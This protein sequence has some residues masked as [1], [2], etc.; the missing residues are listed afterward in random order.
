MARSLA[1]YA[2]QYEWHVF[3]YGVILTTFFV[4]FILSIFTYT[5]VSILY[6][7]LLC[8]FFLAN[9]VFAGYSIFVNNDKAKFV[10]AYSLLPQVILAIA[11][12]VLL[13]IHI[14][15]V[16][17]DPEKLDQVQTSLQCCGLNPNRPSVTTTGTTL[18]AYTGNPNV[19]N[20]AKKSKNLMPKSCCPKL[21]DNDECTADLAWKDFCDDSYDNKVHRYKARA[22]VLMVVTALL[23]C[24]V[25]FSFYKRFLV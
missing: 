6:S 13:A 17:I 14:K 21:D 1:E 10:Y 9:I 15:P 5:P 3:A 4:K 22:I 16:Q 20:K 12:I 19:N 23:Q 8:L 7:S 18:A 11:I 2:S 25:F 24:L